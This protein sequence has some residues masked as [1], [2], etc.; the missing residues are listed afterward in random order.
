MSLWVQ[1]SLQI[2]DC[3]LAE[4]NRVHKRSKYL[5]EHV[6]L[7]RK[8][9][10]QIHF[11]FCPTCSCTA[12]KNRQLHLESDCGPE[13]VLRTRRCWVFLE[14]LKAGQEIR[15]PC[16]E[17]KLDLSIQVSRP[18]FRMHFISLPRLAN[19]RSLHPSQE[20]RVSQSRGHEDYYPLE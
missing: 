19:A 10:F 2:Q 6:V 4:A 8:R 16:K 15:P 9:R 12:N 14:K 20:I 18:K 11:Y 1:G 3:S 5:K 17:S 13:N 7:W